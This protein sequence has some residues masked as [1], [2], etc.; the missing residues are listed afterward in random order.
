MQQGKKPSIL[1]LEPESNQAIE[2]IVS[3]KH[4]EFQMRS[5]P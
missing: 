2:R 3:I 1:K 4:M 5:L